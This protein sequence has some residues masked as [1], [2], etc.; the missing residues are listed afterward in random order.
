M[1][2]DVWKTWA[3]NFVQ[4]IITEHVPNI[5]N[6]VECLNWEAAGVPEISE[7]KHV[8]AWFRLLFPAF[9][10]WIFTTLHEGP[11]TPR[12]GPAQ[13]T[14]RNLPVPLGQV[15]NQANQ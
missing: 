5:R 2:F 3:G 11:A 13:L 6:L 10:S 12:H 4:N 7:Q 9:L 1:G 15:I 8:P 14:H